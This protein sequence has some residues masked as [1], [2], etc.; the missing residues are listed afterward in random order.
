LFID[1]KISGKTIMV[2]GGGAEAYR[3]LQSFLD[4]GA[5]IWVISKNFSDEIQNL[6]DTKKV[7]LLKT[8]IKN[9]QTF[10]DSLN[11]TPDLLLAATDDSKL[12]Q[13]LVA[14]AKS[15]GAMVYAVDNPALSDFILPAVAN[16]GDV[17]I[18][19]STSGK[20]PAMAR[21]LRKRLEKLVT[22][23]DLFAIDLQAEVR[24]ILKKEVS[25]VAVR[26]RLLYA[27][28]NNDKI[29]QALKEGKVREAKEMAIK[30]I[31]KGDPL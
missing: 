13:G 28:L 21:I 22:W 7:S 10:V 30:L 26:R 6:A 3:K 9:A 23:E 2:I 20:S 4:G 25:D 5:K 1:L 11:P 18:A 17:K 14:A 19:I 27:I 24:G 12:N 8:E 15:V 16:I 31:K 29:K